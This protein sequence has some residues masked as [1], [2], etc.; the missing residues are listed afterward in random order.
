MWAKSIKRGK[1]C[2]RENALTKTS[3]LKSSPIIKIIFHRSGSAL[4]PFEA[5]W[6]LML[7]LII[8]QAASSQSQRSCSQWIRLQMQRS[9][10]QSKHRHTCI[11]Q[12][13]VLSVPQC[14][15]FCLLR[16]IF[17]LPFALDVLYFSSFFSPFN[18]HVNLYARL[19]W[20][21]HSKNNLFPPKRPPGPF[22]VS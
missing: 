12:S 2:S 19:T 3:M 4:L 8:P 13:R 14:L 11:V 5:L 20:S 10:P 9:G 17:F 15:S 1:L 6:A 21:C 7:P 16:G 22:F 18:H